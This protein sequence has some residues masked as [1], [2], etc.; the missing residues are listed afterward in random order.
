MLKWS[1]GF[2]LLPFFLAL[3]LN[4]YWYALIVLVVTIVS[5][6][7]HFFSEA[8]EVYYLDVFF[9]SLL[10]LSNFLLLFMGY[11]QLPYSALAVIFALTAL[12]FYFKK[13]KRDYFWNHSLWHIFSAGVCIF[14]LLTFGL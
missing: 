2:F 7:F 4:L 8:S 14:C 6:D 9:S 11:W 12:Y 1:N 10:M 3:S 5:Y 13:S